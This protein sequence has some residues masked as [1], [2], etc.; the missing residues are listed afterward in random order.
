MTTLTDEFNRVVTPEQ[1][2]KMAKRDFELEEKRTRLK[3]DEDEILISKVNSLRALLD[4]TEPFEDENGTVDDGKYPLR[5]L[6]TE[7]NKTI[8]RQK[9]FKLIEKY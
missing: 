1:L 7:E 3:L 2:Q 4:A 6:F 9:L 5:S 8:I